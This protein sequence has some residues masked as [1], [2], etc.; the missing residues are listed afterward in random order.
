MAQ[1]AKSTKNIYML[2]SIICIIGKAYGGRKIPTQNIHG[3]FTSQVRG[4]C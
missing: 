1:N 3:S 2:Y 4:H